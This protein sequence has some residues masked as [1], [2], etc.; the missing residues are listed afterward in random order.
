M[1]RCLVFAATKIIVFIL[2]GECSDYS[3]FT[4]VYCPGCIV[5]PPVHRSIAIQKNPTY[6]VAINC[7]N[8]GLSVDTPTRKKINHFIRSKKNKKKTPRRRRRKRNNEV[9][10]KKI[11]FFRY[12]LLLSIDTLFQYLL[13]KKSKQFFYS[14]R[15]AS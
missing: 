3:S 11:Y 2:R 14:Q 6:I 7:P 4:S 10:R 8:Q 12:I 9:Q 5:G 1:K 13:R 15:K